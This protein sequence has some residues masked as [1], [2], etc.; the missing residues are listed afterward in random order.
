MFSCVETAM[1]APECSTGPVI[2]LADEFLDR[3][4]QGERPPLKEYIDRH[5]E[6]A[7]E[8]REL[9]PAM[10]VMEHIARAGSLREGSKR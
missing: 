7:A 5:P 2:D 3:Y 1:S 10:A 4:R 8:I 9:F 6:L